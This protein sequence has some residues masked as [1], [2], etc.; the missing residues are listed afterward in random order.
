ME[1]IKRIEGPLYMC[2]VHLLT[3]LQAEFFPVQFVDDP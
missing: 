1:A 3:N 2:D